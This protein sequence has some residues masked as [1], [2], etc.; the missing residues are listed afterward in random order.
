MVAH[1]WLTGP[2]CRQQ[3]ARHDSGASVIGRRAVLAVGAALT[4]RQGSAALPVPQGNALAFRL[5]RHGSDIGRHTLSFEPQA[6]ALTVRVAVDAVVTLLSIPIVRY[7]HRVVEAWQAGTLV[8]VTGETNKNGRQEWVSASRDS[9]GLVVLGS[10]TEQYIAPEP[11]GCTSYWNR[12]L[13]DGP[14][15]S[16]ED[17]VLLRPKVVKELAETI[18]L[19]SGGTIAADHYNLSGAFKV[20]L[21]YDQ[22][23]TWASLGLAAAD[24]SYVHYER[25]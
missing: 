17:G 14:M 15:I 6:D 25:L 3:R 18:P 1:L 7:K 22:A 23:N 9:Q 10:K 12:G 19:A 21:W 5:I 11:A 20:D 2:K 13:L 16:L 4:V 8:S 24:G